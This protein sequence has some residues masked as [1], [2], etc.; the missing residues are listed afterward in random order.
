MDALLTAIILWLSANF[1][2]P[3]TLDPP[4]VQFSPPEQIAALRQDSSGEMI[5][6]GATPKPVGREVVSVYVDVTKTIHLPQGWKGNTPADLSILVHEMV[7]HLQNVARMRFACPQER[8]K[9]AYQAQEQ[10]LALFGRN[11][12]REFEIDPFTLLVSTN[13]FY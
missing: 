9:L 8:E 1:A 10:W 11:L 7:H 5:R 4:K 2:L 12:E 6:S 3:S 13:C